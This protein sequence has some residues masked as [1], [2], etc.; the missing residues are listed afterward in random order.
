MNIKLHAI[1]DS[2]GRPP[3]LFVT[4]GQ[5]SDHIGA[6]VLLSGLPKVGCLGVSAMTPTGSGR[7]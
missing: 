7:R 5:A 4:A 2:Q 6:R 1:R 3:D